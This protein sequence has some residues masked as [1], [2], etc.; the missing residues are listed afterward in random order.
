MFSKRIRNVRPSGT[1]ML[2]N[3]VGR[4]KS[5]GLDILSFTLGEP[6][7]VTPP[8]IIEA[9]K[10][11]LDDGMTHYTTSLGLPELRDEI[12]ALCRR[13]NN[14]D[15]TRDNVI[16]M[17]SKFAIMASLQAF[18][19]P[20]DKVLIPNPGWVSYGPMVQLAGGTPIPVKMRHDGGWYW[21]PD[22]IKAHITPK[23]K[24]IIL[25]TPSNP[26]G[27][28]L[29]EKHLREIVDIA[30]ENDMM[31]IS[32]EVYENLIYEG[33]HFSVASVE[34]AFDRMITVS[35]FSKSYAMTGWRTGWLVAND[36]SVKMLNKIMQHSLTCLP[37]FVQMGA[38]EAIRHGE[39]DIIKMRE[40]F[41]KRRDMVIP[42]LNEID[43]ITCEMPK[44]AFYAFFKMDI[45]FNSMDLAEMLLYK[46][47][48]AVTPGSAFGSA[49]SNYI[50]MSYAASMDDLD[51]G[52]KRIEKFTNEITRMT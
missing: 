28:V 47:H 38:L 46:A 19:N 12:A 10:K 11:A 32:D 37:P 3:K 36:E 7:F 15:A 44:G 4:L 22:D 20:G 35:G 31:I 48:V 50:R 39:E 43:G 18:V 23:C 30:I 16:L 34:E 2:A 33:S 42:R 24:T 49:G 17:P 29:D 21:D 52:I 26:Q 51:E 9:C 6:D 14:I 8:Y 41:R 40:E 45:G 1:V 27:S 5:Q 25:N 13:K